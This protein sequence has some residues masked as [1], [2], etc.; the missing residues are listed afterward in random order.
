MSKHCYTIPIGQDPAVHGGYVPS[1]VI[2]G[3]SGHYPLT[4]RGKHSMPWVWGKT[5][6]EAQATCASYNLRHFGVDENAEFRIVLST[7]ANVK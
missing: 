7:M 6:E 2:E 5:L 1:L 3:K 4:G